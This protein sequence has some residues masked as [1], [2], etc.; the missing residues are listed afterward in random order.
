[1]RWVPT[2]GPKALLVFGSNPVVSAPRARRVEARLKSLDLLV[3]ADF[4]LSETAAIADVVLPTAQWAEEEGT[5]TNLEGRVIRR[6]ALREPPPGVWTD[7]EVIAADGGAAGRPVSVSRATRGPS[8][9]SCGA[10]RRAA[11]PTTP[12]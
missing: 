3:V 5:M 11:R 6:Q 7:L 1:M 4:V 12:A 2:H 8:S 9:R 10:P